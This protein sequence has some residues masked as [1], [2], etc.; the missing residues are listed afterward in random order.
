MCDLRMTNKPVGPL[1]EFE[2]IQLLGRQTH[3][4]NALVV[5]GLVEDELEK[6]LLTAGRELPNK[7]AKEIFGGMG[8]LHSFS[9]KI[10]IAYM[11]E[12][13]DL[14]VRDDLHVIKSI[15]NKFAHTTRFV[16][17]DSEH[18]DQDCR[19]LSNWRADLPN[20][21]AFRR[22]A[23]ARINSIRLK[24]EHL[25]FAKA[26]AEPPPIVETDD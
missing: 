18:V 13:I 2:L 8:P 4:G 12:L 21:E 6:L 23:L 17:F 24:T 26:L 9:G 25:L 16:Y 7:Q 22:C 14:A 5:A 20:E 19:R 11:F 3:A 15:R 1:T 10:E